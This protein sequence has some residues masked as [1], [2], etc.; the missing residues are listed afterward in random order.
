MIIAKKI[1]YL[2]AALLVLVGCQ[3]QSKETMV[4]DGVVLVE[5]GN[6]LGAIVLFSNALEQDPNYVAA[7]YQLG[8]AY[9]K[10]GKFDKAERELQK[11]RLQSPDNGDVLLDIAALYFAMSRIDDAEVEI[12][13]FLEKHP[14]SSRSQEYYGRILSVRSDLHGAESLFREAI[15][16]D[17]KNIDA[18]LA[19]AQ[20]YL[21]QGRVGDARTLL[22]VV[23]Q[24]FPK[25]KAAYFMLAALEAHQG[26]KVEAL[27]AYKQVV[28][29]DSN[30]VGALYMT[31][32]LAL[33]MGNTVE[34]QRVADDL[35]TRFPEHP[36]TSRLAGMLFYVGGD[37]ES[38]AIKLRLSLKSM[39]DLSGYYFLGL[40]EYRLGHFEL[41]LN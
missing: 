2:V 11:V 6:P 33:D 17:G 24:D 7:R 10:S 1:L 18:R 12:V 28:L 15:E 22:T 23:V 9:Y 8:L 35:G 21:Q 14:K 13:R 16:L 34:A 41:A 4:Q 5:Q 40:A 25:V 31:G 36:A 39:S 26:N 3:E 29:I 30:D 27:E 38:A 20:H 32:M 37:L 19:L